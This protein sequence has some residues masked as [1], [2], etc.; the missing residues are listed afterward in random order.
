MESVYILLMLATAV[1][2]A[3]VIGNFR[4]LLENPDY[5]ILENDYTN[6]RP[7]EMVEESLEV[8]VRGDRVPRQVMFLFQGSCPAGTARVGA[9][10]VRGDEDRTTSDK[11][12]LTVRTERV[13]DPVALRPSDLRFIWEALSSLEGSRWCLGYYCAYQGLK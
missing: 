12:K 5:A 11:S 7:S 10:C 3:S 2:S 9:R 8:K 13:P 6:I 4:P 1:A